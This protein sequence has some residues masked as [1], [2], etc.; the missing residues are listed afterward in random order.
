MSDP[1]PDGINI[2]ADPMSMP[3]VPT[4][5]PDAAAAAAA[6]VAPGYLHN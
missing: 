4:G 6:A 2:A 1:A 3:P 5:T